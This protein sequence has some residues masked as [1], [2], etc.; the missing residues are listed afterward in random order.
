MID[1]TTS[2]GRIIT[3]ALRLAAARPWAAVSL[4][5]IADAAAINLAELRHEFPSKSAIVS[6]F[7]R[8]IDDV[9]LAKAA[10]PQPG[11]GPR[12]ALF[13]VVMSR[14]DAMQPYKAGLKSI[15]ADVGFDT[16]LARRLFASQAWMLSAAG[17]PLD[18]IGGAVRVFGLTS[19][20]T[21][22]LR[23]WLDD[24]DAGLARTMAV[25]D[26]RLRR[27]EQSIQ[28]FDSLCGVFPRLF[29]M[30]G[31]RRGGEQPAP[32]TDPAESGAAGQRP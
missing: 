1:P 9:V 13:E 6:G 12:D 7:T 26:R 29:G 8:A 27:G 15:M 19:L 2:K 14:L 17:I 32:S 21:S 30:F 28:T 31:P 10:K 25:L 18:G 22:V 4:L 3:A 20:Y 11:T 24:D 5:D 23:T 16:E